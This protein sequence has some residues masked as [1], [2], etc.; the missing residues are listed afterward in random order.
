M[1]KTPLTPEQI[2][3]Q[4]LITKWNAEKSLIGTELNKCNSIDDV[5]TIWGK[6]VDYQIIK[7][8]KEMIN[9]AKDNFNA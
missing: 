2:E 9:L 7:D 5:K 1:K 4:R 8:F 3:K 6:Y